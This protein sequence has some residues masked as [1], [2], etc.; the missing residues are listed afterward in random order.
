MYGHYKSRSFE[1]TRRT[2]TFTTNPKRPRLTRITE[3]KIEA[4]YECW[5]LTLLLALSLLNSAYA[6]ISNEYQL[7]AA[8]LFH[9]AQ[10]VDWPPTALPEEGSPFNVCT[11]G[12]DSFRGE[13][14]NVMNGKSIGS[15]I[16]R[17]RHLKQIT[18]AHNCQILFIGRNESKKLPTLLA[19]LG[20]DPIMTVG[21]TDDFVQQG[22]IIGFR[23][24]DQ[25]I[26]FEINLV[27]AGHVN[28]KISSRLLLL[29]TNVIHN[30]A[31][32]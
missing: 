22:G 31:D 20:D 2:T 25:K 14:D 17:V 28:L 6:Q 21:E 23:S 19:A 32:R 29:A 13:L 27:A 9:F 24:E 26:R 18:E 16:T 11:V 1:G 10:L 30:G 7:K 3:N 5:V 15:R 4:A 8:F 12:G